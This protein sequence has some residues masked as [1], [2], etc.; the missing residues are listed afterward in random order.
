MCDSVTCT[1]MIAGKDTPSSCQHYKQFFLASVNYHFILCS[2]FL[3]RNLVHVYEDV[4]V[5][6]YILF[7]YFI[8]VGVA[9]DYWIKWHSLTY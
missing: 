6:I 2:I 3:Q 1:R 7:Y 5:L 8:Y 9:G 4:T